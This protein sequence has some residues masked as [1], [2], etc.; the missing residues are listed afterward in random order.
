MIGGDR[1][2]GTGV[3]GRVW[4]SNNSREFKILIEEE[5]WQLVGEPQFTR[6]G[7][8]FSEYTGCFVSCPER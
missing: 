2:K 1:E 5:Q 4:Q 8:M 6:V 7:K 3:V